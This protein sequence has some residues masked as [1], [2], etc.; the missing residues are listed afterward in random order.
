MSRGKEQAPSVK[1]EEPK[2]DLFNAK[3]TSEEADG[4]FNQVKDALRA[5]QESPH[6][7]LIDKL[8]GHLAKN[9]M[10][11]LIHSA[12][13]IMPL[14]L[15]DV[16]RQ[17]QTKEATPENLNQLMTDVLFFLSQFKNTGVELIG[18]RLKELLNLMTDGLLT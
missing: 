1:P 17:G 18:D 8:R 6:G 9:H 4:Y 15:Q 11:Q 7:N 12:G 10:N 3:L 5:A 2:V 14:T 13:I 16:V